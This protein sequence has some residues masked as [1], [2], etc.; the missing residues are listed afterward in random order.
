MSASGQIL[1]KKSFE[2]DERNFPG[3]LVRFAR[4]DVK[5]HIAS[6][7]NDH[8]ASYPRYRALQ[9]RNRPN[10]NVCEISGVVRFST[11]ATLSGTKQT[12]SDVRVESVM[13]NKADI[14]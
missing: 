12:W 2:G 10:I 4:R 13:R 3:P 9:R 8:G 7:K 1:L 11:F 14:D 5:D 6:Q